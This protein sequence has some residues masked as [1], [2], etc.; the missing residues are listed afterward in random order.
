MNNLY[1]VVIFCKGTFINAQLWARDSHYL[2]KRIIA[3]YG[4]NAQLIDFHAI[5]NEN[6]TSNDEIAI[7]QVA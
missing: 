5:P 2:S 1:E 7:E 4:P 6:G 3:I